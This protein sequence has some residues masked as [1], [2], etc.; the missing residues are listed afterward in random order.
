MNLGPLELGLILVI[1]LLIFGA[2]KL[3]EVF[4]SMGAGLREFREAAKGPEDEK[5]SDDK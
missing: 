4:R 3:P 5:K 1:V 2:G